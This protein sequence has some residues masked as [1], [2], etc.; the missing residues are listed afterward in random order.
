MG[1]CCGAQAAALEPEEVVGLRNKRKKQNKTKQKTRKTKKKKKKKN[2]KNKK[3][4]EREI[5][6]GRCKCNYI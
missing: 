1:A 5:V 3:K 6:M 2:N 4:E